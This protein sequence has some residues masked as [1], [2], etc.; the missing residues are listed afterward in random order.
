[1]A[2]AA[3]KR[4]QLAQVLRADQVVLATTESAWTP[5]SLT[6]MRSAIAKA[7]PVAGRRPQL[8]LICGLG[9]S[10]LTDTTE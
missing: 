6:A 8:L 5:A 10:K 4:V 2:A 3:D 1:M 9:T 7:D